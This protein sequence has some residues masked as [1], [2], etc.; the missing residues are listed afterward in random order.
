MKYYDMRNHIICIKD[1]EIMSITFNINIYDMGEG[2][3]KKN[4]HTRRPCVKDYH[5]HH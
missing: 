3:R 2:E 1:I 4:K 5:V